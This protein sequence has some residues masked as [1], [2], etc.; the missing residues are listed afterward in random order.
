MKPYVTI[1]DKYAQRFQGRTQNWALTIPVIVVVCILFAV[2][3]AA[4]TGGTKMYMPGALIVL[5]IA[6]MLKR[7]KYED[8]TFFVR[9]GEGDNFSF[10][11]VNSD[12]Q[13]YENSLEEYSYWY[14]CGPVNSKGSQ[15]E[16]YFEIKSPHETLY[17]KEVVTWDHPPK[18]WPISDVRI[19]TRKETILING[20]QELAYKIDQG[21]A[22]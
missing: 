3:S 21:T 4:A 13:Q 6:W 2:I 16:L 10:G 1:F 8:I 19:A 9:K 20:L 12:R 22:K 17:L 15:F 5:P 14:A 18:D 11:I 7:D